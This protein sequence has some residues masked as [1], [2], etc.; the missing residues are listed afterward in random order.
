MDI[1]EIYINKIKC[2]LSSSDSNNKSIALALGFIELNK[3]WQDDFKSFNNF[4]SKTFG[5]NRYKTYTYLKFCYKFCD[6]RKES[7]FLAY[8]VKLEFCEI[9]F[10]KLCLCFDL[11]YDEFVKLGISNKLSS[12]EIRKLIKDY[13]GYVPDLEFKKRGEHIE[14]DFKLDKYDCY[15]TNYD[16]SYIS[17]VKT[18]KDLSEGLKRLR[19][20]ILKDNDNVYVVVKVSKS[21]WGA[22]GYETK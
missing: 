14:T 11:T 2:Y 1:L 9:D 7:N 10:S 5:F 20:N 19:D 21:E 17:G 22:L 16:S 8:Y 6:I 13:F 15:F 12:N 3:L 4:A 18:K